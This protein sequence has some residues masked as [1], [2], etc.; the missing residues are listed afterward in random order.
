MKIEIDSATAD[1]ITLSVLKEH[2]SMLKQIIKDLKKRAVLKPFEQEDLTTSIE[3]L[4]SI[5]Q[6]IKMFQP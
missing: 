3:G 6:V 4:A 1:G 2:A 5:N